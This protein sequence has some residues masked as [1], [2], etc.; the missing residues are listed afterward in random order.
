MI[1]GVLDNFAEEVDVRVATIVLEVAGDADDVFEAAAVCVFRK[2]GSTV[3]VG[4]DVVVSRRVGREL[5][6]FKELRVDVFDAVPDVDITAPTFASTRPFDI[7]V[8]ELEFVTVREAN[9]KN[10]TPISNIAIIIPKA[11]FTIFTRFTLFT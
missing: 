8:A 3:T 1:G 11:L 5:N 4:I 10:R 6:D 9:I 2:V 7:I